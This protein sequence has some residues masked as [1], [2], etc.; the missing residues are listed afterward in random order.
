M[1]AVPE[2]ARG[3]VA[4][5]HQLAD[6]VGD[7][8]ADL[9]RCRPRGAPFL[10]VVAGAEN[11]GDG[12]VVDPPTVDGAAEVVERGFDRGLELHDRASEL[13][14]HLLGD[15]GVV[16]QVEPAA[17]QRVGVAGERGARGADRGERVRVGEER[18]AGQLGLGAPGVGCSRGPRVRLPP[19]L[20]QLHLEWPERG[21]DLGDDRGGGGRGRG[22][23]RHRRD[24]REG[25]RRRR[26]PGRGGRAVRRPSGLRS[27]W[28]PHPARRRRRTRR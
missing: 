16:Q 7:F 4:E 18:P 25:R 15:E 10:G 8:R 17:Q 9:L 27:R 6:A 20:R 3:L 1:V 19:R 22:G 2:R 11:L 14:R 21:F 12:V 28:R 26:L 13:G 5:T 24:S 23:G